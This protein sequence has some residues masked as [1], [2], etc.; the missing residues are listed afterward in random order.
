MRLI[1]DALVAVT[2][3]SHAEPMVNSLSV[4]A[5]EFD[6]YNRLLARVAEV[7]GTVD[8]DYATVRTALE[9]CETCGKGVG[10]G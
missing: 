4:P 5:S 7:L 10:R 8:D 1:R 9:H 6:D 3:G 2:L